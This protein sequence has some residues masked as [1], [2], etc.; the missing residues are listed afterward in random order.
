MVGQFAIKTLPFY[1]RSFCNKHRSRCT[2][3]NLD[4]IHHE[5]LL[6]VIVICHG[7]EVKIAMSTI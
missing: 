7:K 1:S 6:T 2:S 3:I 5:G 4:A